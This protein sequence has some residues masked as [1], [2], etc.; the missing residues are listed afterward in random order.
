MDKDDVGLNQSIDTS[1]WNPIELCS[2]S[3]KLRQGDPLSPLLFILVMDV[4]STMLD[5]TLQSGVLYGVPLGIV[6]KMCHLQYA[7]NLLI[8]EAGVERIAKSLNLFSTYLR[9]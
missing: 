5:H 8:L 9:G 6:R 4:L 3:K 2:I 1:E 7:D